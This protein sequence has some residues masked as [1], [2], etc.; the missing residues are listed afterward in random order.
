MSSDPGPSPADA[1]VERGAL[2]EALALTA[3]AE[4]LL[5][6]GQIDE[7]V[8]IATRVGDFGLDL[9][10]TWR[11]LAAACDAQGD[12]PAA[13]AAYDQLLATATDRDQISG[14]MGRVALRLGDYAKA[15]RLLKAHIRGLGA[16]P[17]AIA[18]LAAAQTGLQ[19]FDRA[20]ATLKAALEA[21]PAQPLLWAALGRLLSVEGR[22]AHAV[23]FFEEGLRLDPGSADAR[24]GLADALLLSDGEVDRALSLSAEA[25]AAAASN[26]RPTVNDDHARRLLGSGRLAEGWAALATEMIPPAADIRVAAPPWRPDM[27]LDGPLLVIGEENVIHEV[28][29][30]QVIPD[31][32][33]EG[34]PL[35]LAVSPRW[36]VLARRSFPQAAVVPLLR[37][38]GG[39]RRRVAA[40][41]DS[42]HMHG[43]KLLAAWRTL[44]STL[45][46]H[47]ARP[48]DF[49][50]P[51]PYLVADKD[52]VRHWRD[53]LSGLGPGPKIGV[54][55]RQPLADVTRPY[56]IPSLPELQRPLSVPGLH[57]ISLQE[58]EVM[59]EAE[60]IEGALGL[61][62]H[63]PAWLD[64][65]GLDDLA[66]LACALDVVVGP[67]GATTYVAAACG[68]ET[69]FLSTP[70]HWAMLGSD[71][72]PWFPASRVILSDSADWTEAME[73]LGQSLYA[74]AHP[75]AD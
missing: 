64:R 68:A 63:E 18:D 3:E 35:I 38:S 28:L 66:A 40:R 29:L 47:R 49:A 46:D 71:S 9:E 53:W 69:W 75:S 31:L 52:R 54:R 58:G 42:P 37:R 22:H 72:Y 4:A 48:A 56:E 50:N 13:L 43:G 44:R 41:L 30:A 2:D 11:V 57:L 15:E 74:L 45:P 17:Q 25:V 21:D 55:W 65:D 70:G 12:L 27:P 62:V 24:A 23:I 32:I 34:R 7:A 67:P 14:P 8:R 73:E 33:A 39:G 10:R 5:A 19:T 1:S 60:W 20:H 16:A 61:K 36:E 26:D 59:G 6:A 51:A